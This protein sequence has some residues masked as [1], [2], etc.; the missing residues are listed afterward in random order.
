MAGREDRKHY[1]TGAELTPAYLQGLSEG[2]TVP[3]REI[4]NFVRRVSHVYNPDKPGGAITR[5]V[6]MIKKTRR[7]SIVGFSDRSINLRSDQVR[8]V[9]IEP[10]HIK[11]K[12]MFVAGDGGY[13]IDAGGAAQL[14]EAVV[15]R[16]VDGLETA[17]L[18]LVVEAVLSMMDAKQF[19]YVDGQDMVITIPYGAEIGDLPDAGSFPAFSGTFSA[20]GANALIEIRGAKMAYRVQP[21]IDFP[22]SVAFINPTTAMRMLTNT[23]IK[24]VYV[25]T[26]PSDPDNLA[27]TYEGFM[28]DGVTFIIL[29]KSYASADGEQPAIADGYAVVTVPVHPREGGEPIEWHSCE[30]IFNRQNAEEPYYDTIEEGTDPSSIGPRLYDN[31]IPAPSHR[32][33][34]ARWKLFTP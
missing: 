9:M 8:E 20:P 6:N 17:R 13:S 15:L 2:T 19:R 29:H 27:E 12:S 23:G 3:H 26:Q 28:Y 22:F 10:F 34:I 14:D 25:P 5:R 32:G 7:A 11:N 1:L 4:L 16:A 24:A 33:I 21:G 18:N 30:T 31:G